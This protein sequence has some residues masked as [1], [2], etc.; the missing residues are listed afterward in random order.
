MCFVSLETT[1][2]RA[3]DFILTIS[4][5]K[6]APTMKYRFKI[7]IKT[8]RS[9]FFSLLIWIS[10]LTFFRAE[11]EEKT[12]LSDPK[13]IALA[14]KYGKNV[15]QVVLRYLIQRNLIVIPKSVTPSRIQGN[16]QVRK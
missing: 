10:I 6:A 9:S 1:F 4:S 14:E 3:P 12:V 8:N 11:K 2:T 7:F 13:I 16:L 5:N 15:G